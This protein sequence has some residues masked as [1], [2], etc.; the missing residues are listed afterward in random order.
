MKKILSLFLAVTLLCGCATLLA[1]CGAP[2]DPGAEIIVYLGDVVYDFDPSDYVVDDNEAKILSLMYEPLF[3][4]TEGGRLKKAAAKKYSIDE[5]ARTI[6]IDLRESYW[7]DNRP[8]QAGDFIFAWRDLLMNPKRATPAAALLYDIE[9]AL[10]IKNGTKDMYT[11]G[12]EKVDID[13]LR[14]TYREGADVDQLLKNLA[15]VYTAPVRQ[16]VYEQVADGWSKQA[17]TIATNGPFTFKTYN[18]TEDEDNPGTL[19]SARFSLAR[20]LGYHQDPTT[21]KYTKQVTPESLVTFWVGDNAVELTYSQIE[22][23]T[24]FFMGDMDAAA[25]ADI[26]DEAVVSDLLSTYTYVFNTENPLFA[27]EHVR[28]ALSLALDRDAMQKAVVFGKAAQGMHPSTEGLIS[29]TADLTAAQA[30][31]AK[32]QTAAPRTFTLTV[33]N[34]EDSVLLADMAKTAWEALGFTVTVQAVDYNSH[35]VYLDIQDL[36]TPT[37]IKDS[38]VQS[39]AKD[40]SFGN[41]TFD[42]LAVDWQMYSEDP[43]V[44]LCEF[45]SDMNGCGVD[46]RTNTAVRRTSIS[47]WTSQDYDKLLKDAFQADDASAREQLLADAEKMLCEKMPVIPVLYNQNFAFVSKKLRHVETD[48]FG[49]FN[50]TKASLKNYSKYTVEK[51]FPEQDDE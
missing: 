16:D 35:Q 4:L 26:Q 43:F 25:R 21:T 40:A 2:K 15:S 13:T 49:F 20:N 39:I 34:D 32:A 44:G 30:E 31:L 27:D 8:V 51:I 42:V 46:F 18:L 41:R 24:M 45:T 23:D 50:F 29:V 12:V 1:S 47:G 33:N 19:A 28:L 22:N 17:D 9:N 14:I 38:V 3:S 5:D 6:T 48:G 7:S 36:Q 10:E 11:F 37:I